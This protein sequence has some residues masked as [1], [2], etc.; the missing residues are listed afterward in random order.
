MA[1]TDEIKLGRLA[2]SR[3]LCSQEQVLSALRARNAAPEGP[4]LGTI[5]VER[6]LV[7]LE[8]LS[9]LRAALLR[10]EEQRER[11]EAS[12]EREISLGGTRE[13]IARACLEEAL[14]A[15]PKDRP[16]ALR[17]LERLAAEFGDTESGNKALAHLKAEQG[18][19]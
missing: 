12:T 11:H 8:A 1:D 15:L 13:A 2:V 7:T 10:G 4:T 19:A 18:Q 5:L 16:G 3:G 9:E 17:E 14:T 6:G